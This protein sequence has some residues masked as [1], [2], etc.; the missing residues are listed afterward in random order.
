MTSSTSASH[1]DKPDLLRSVQAHLPPK[2]A[3]PA[4]KD[5]S[6]TEYDQFL[7]EVSDLL[8]NVHR[9]D[10]A[11]WW[12][13][14]LKGRGWISLLLAPTLLQPAMR[15]ITVGKIYH[16]KGTHLRRAATL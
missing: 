14:A 1:Q 3:R 8:N 13:V 2:Q 12:A 4:Q 15:R 10:T 5:G 7:N 16:S 11:K 6:K 9:H